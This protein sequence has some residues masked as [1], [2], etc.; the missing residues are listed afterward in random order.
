[1]CD[2]AKDAKKSVKLYSMAFMIGEDA[3]GEPGNCEIVY[4]KLDQSIYPFAKDIKFP[5]IQN[6][7]KLVK[8]DELLLPGRAK[9]S[10]KARS[11]T[12]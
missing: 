11:S 12:D 1:M 3:E 6:R 5:V 4:K 9:A 10:K 7:I 8:G 2:D